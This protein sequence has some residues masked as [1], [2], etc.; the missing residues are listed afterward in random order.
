MSELPGKAS[1]PALTNNGYILALNAMSLGFAS[2]NIFEDGLKE[3]ITNLFGA[4]K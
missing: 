3:F 4:L 2:V 1:I